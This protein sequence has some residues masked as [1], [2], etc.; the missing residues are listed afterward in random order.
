MKEVRAR[1]TALGH[2]NAVVPGLNVAAPV[3]GRYTKT[4][5]GRAKKVTP[6]RCKYLKTYKKR[7]VQH[8]PIKQH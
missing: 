3:G 4:Y 7:K 6:L 5:K 1:L 2:P 8:K